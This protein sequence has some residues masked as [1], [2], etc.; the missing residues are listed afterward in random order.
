MIICTSDF[1]NLKIF[2][3]DILHLSIEKKNYRGLQSWISGSLYHNYYIELYIKDI[4]IR[5]EY[6]KED[7]WKTILD[8]LNK[9]L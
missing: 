9:N 8:L 4:K 7:I 6:D 5:L 2:I 3:N 1:K